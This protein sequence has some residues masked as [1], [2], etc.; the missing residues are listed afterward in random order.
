M[1]GACYLGFGPGLELGVLH[2]TMIRLLV[3]AGV[4]RVVVRR[5]WLPG[6]LIGLDRLMIVWATWL[7]IS[8]VF[9]KEPGSDLIFKLGY[10]FDACGLYF[11]LRIFCTSFTDVVR[12]CR[13][14]VIVLL[15]LAAGMLSEQVLKR[16]P[17][18]VL[19]NTPETPM[20]RDGKIRAFGTFAH[21]I[22]AGTAG[23]VTFPLLAGLWR[24]H[25]K[26]ALL[27]GTVCLLIVVSS[28]SSG[29]VMSTVFSVAA[30]CLWPYRKWLPTIR[31]ASVVIYILL[32][33]FMKVPA[34][35]IIA[36]MDVTGSS[37]GWHRA[38]LIEMSLAHLNEWWLAGTDH[39]RHWMPS[40]VSW[41]AN[42]T[43]ITNHYLQMGV[44]G[45]L[46]L[47]FLFIGLL[48]TAFVYVG[49]RVKL[50]RRIR[51]KDRF[52]I[53]ALGS[54]LFAHATTFISVSYFDQSILFLYLTLA[55]IGSSV[56]QPGNA[57]R[58]RL[59]SRSSRQNP[60]ESIAHAVTVG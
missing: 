36:R 45:G 21:P 14:T 13:S 23:A 39:T 3:V 51:M 25:R 34:Y 19:G 60:S 32:D 27:G 46:P 17:F 30:L 16:N 53:W 20:V 2:F 24:H 50:V 5:E 9:H 59:V 38:R 48:A 44:M 52:V 35:Y 43:D 1:M 58:P 6:G 4:L 54:A 41:N 49:R 29:P 18:S 40:G 28:G 33:I 47:M 56:H 12:L 22:L 11:L 31:R 55:A 42:H 7:C 57:D 37:T 26:T 15:P 10:L 8:S